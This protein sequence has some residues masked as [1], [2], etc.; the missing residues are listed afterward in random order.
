MVFKEVVNNLF[1]TNKEMKQKLTSEIFEIVELENELE[2]HMDNLFKEILFENEVNSNSHSLQRKIYLFLKQKLSRKLNKM[3]VEMLLLK[4]QL[5]NCTRDV[6]EEILTAKEHMD[7]E[8]YS[9]RKELCLLEDEIDRLC[10][11]ED[12]LVKRERDLISFVESIG[13]SY[14]EVNIKERGI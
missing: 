9:M 8:K 5:I 1:E 11:S 13:E 6:I 4:K 12:N 14:F 2:N 10:A 7:S 3:K